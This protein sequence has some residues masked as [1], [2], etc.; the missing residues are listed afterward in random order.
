M[1][2]GYLNREE[3]S[4]IYR[5]VMAMRKIPANIFTG[6]LS[7]VANK[8]LMECEVRY[9]DFFDDRFHSTEFRTEVAKDISSAVFHAQSG[10]SAVEK[11]LSYVQHACINVTVNYLQ[12]AHKQLQKFT[13]NMS[14]STDPNEYDPCIK[15]LNNIEKN[16]EAEITK[17]E[18][19]SIQSKAVR[20]E[21]G[22]SQLSHEIQHQNGLFLQPKPDMFS[23]II[24]RNDGTKLRFPEGKS[25]LIA[26]CPNCRYEFV[27]D[28]SLPDFSIK[29]RPEIHKKSI[30]KRISG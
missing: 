15:Y 4:I 1:K 9:Q 23:V 25:N 13:S 5:L 16:Q 24:C 10:L 27:A 28:T 29:R 26:I 7:V 14:C 6:G 17:S 2:V 21:N 30:W 11:Q 18:I 20:F 3:L 19:R 8:V 22:I 12:H